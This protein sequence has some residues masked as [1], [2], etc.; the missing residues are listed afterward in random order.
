MPDHNPLRDEWCAAFQRGQSYSQVRSTKDRIIRFCQTF[1]PMVLAWN[2][3]PFAWYWRL[4]IVLLVVPWG[5]G[6]VVAMYREPP[7]R[8]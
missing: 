1:I 3:L 5:V 2:L 7:W 6:V 8:S 4:A